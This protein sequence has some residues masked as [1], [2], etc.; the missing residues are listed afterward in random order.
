MQNS[1]FEVN[2]LI[3]ANQMMQIF[4]IPSFS[5]FP[6]T[7]N[8]YN[9]YS[10]SKIE[11]KIKKFQYFKMNAIVDSILL[12]TILFQPLSECQELC[13][14][15]WNKNY[16]FLV[17]KIF[18]SSFL[19]HVLN[20]ISASYSVKNAWNRFKIMNDIEISN[21]ILYLILMLNF[22]FSC[23][24]NLPNVLLMNIES[25]LNNNSWRAAY[26][27][28]KLVTQVNFAK[29]ISLAHLIISIL[30]LLV[31]LMLVVKLGLLIKA[32]LNTNKIKK[33]Y[34]DHHK[35]KESIVIY[36]RCSSISSHN[37]ET[38]LK[39]F[40]N[41]KLV[42]DT[43]FFLF[44]IIFVFIIEQFLKTGF[45]I[46]FLL[47]TEPLELFFIGTIY[48]FLSLITLFFHFYIFYKFNKHFSQRLRY[49]CSLIFASNNLQ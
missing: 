12:L 47:F 5:L 18:I 20:T 34:K 7:I 40:S 44:W 42:S 37:L 32:Q 41:K 26:Q 28:F 8:L 17:Y 2:N 25:N 16:W 49:L 23:I 1:T 21:K 3:L 29:K 19:I 43:G 33:H 24:L 46:V 11:L 15:W 4:L 10:V 22:I 9:A 36:Q 14:R 48:I 39:R 30:V 6:I 35:R 31:S 38:I 13:S 27:T 45:V